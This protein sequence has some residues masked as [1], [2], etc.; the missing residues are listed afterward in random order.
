M[1]RRCVYLVSK[2]AHRHEQKLW[3]EDKTKWIKDVTQD[4]DV[5]K[6]PGPY[7]TSAGQWNNNTNPFGRWRRERREPWLKYAGARPVAAERRAIPANRQNLQ[8]MTR[9]LNCWQGPHRNDGPYHRPNI[10]RNFRNFTS[11]SSFSRFGVNRGYYVKMGGGHSSHE[12]PHN[13]VWINSRWQQ[14]PRLHQPRRYCN[15]NVC[16]RECISNA[17]AVAVGSRDNNQSIVTTMQA[18]FGGMLFP[19]IPL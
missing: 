7:F 13:G 8:V 17:A 9:H 14:P 6:N 18:I 16:S 4:G 1:E 15:S 12:G 2:E 19:Q 11:V 10:N 5:Q 3:K